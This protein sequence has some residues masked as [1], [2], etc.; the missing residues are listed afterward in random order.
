[1]KS[2]AMRRHEHARIDLSLLRSISLPTIGSRQGQG[3]SSFFALGH[4]NPRAGDFISLDRSPREADAPR[5][6]HIALISDPV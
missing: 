6:F 5:L 2:P 1:M 4:A 3:E